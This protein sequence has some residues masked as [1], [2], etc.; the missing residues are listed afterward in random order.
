MSDWAHARESLFHYLSISFPSRLPPSLVLLATK[1]LSVI[2]NLLAVVFGRRWL[3][4]LISSGMKLWRVP[5][6]L[7]VMVILFFCASFVSD[8]C[9]LIHLSFISSFRSAR[10][11]FGEFNIVCWKIVSVS[12]I[13]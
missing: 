7:I 6:L 4:R 12:H 13:S 3:V 1:V 8:Y 5:T 9:A 2:V 10:L 11:C